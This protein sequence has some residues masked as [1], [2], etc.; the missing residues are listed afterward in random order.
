MRAQD[1]RGFD[2]TNRDHDLALAE[3]NRDQ[4]SPPLATQESM[5][6]NWPAWVP[7][8][9]DRPT[10]PDWGKVY[11][12]GR[13]IIGYDCQDVTH[14]RALKQFMAAARIISAAGV[15]AF[16]LQWTGWLLACSDLADMPTPK[17][18]VSFQPIFNR[19]TRRQAERAQRRGAG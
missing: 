6:E 14:R 4:A 12:D 11:P 3:V 17:P 9:L 19:A 8:I 5:R 1:I 7:V 18:A 10:G 16:K 15:E 2:P 13:G